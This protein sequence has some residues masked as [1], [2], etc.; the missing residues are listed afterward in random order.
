MSILGL[1]IWCW[2]THRCALPW[3]DSFS[4][5]Q[6]SLV[7]GLRPPGLSRDIFREMGVT[8]VRGS[9]LV[10]DYKVGGGVEDKYY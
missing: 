8:K 5:S 2:I 4:H 1:T 7:A 10:G 3:G 6:K 9:A